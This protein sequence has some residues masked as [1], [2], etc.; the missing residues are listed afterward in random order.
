MALALEAGT[1]SLPASG[2]VAVFAPREGFD[3]SPLPKDRC[4]IVT[5]YKPDFDRFEAAG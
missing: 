2:P 3:L 1:P 5:G 4:I